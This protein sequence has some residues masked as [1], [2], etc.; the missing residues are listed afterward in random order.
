M[1]YGD[2]SYEVTIEEGYTTGSARLSTG[3]VGTY[4]YELSTGDVVVITPAESATVTHVAEGT[5]KNAYSYTLENSGYYSN[6]TKTEGDL[7]I[8]PATLTVKTE[9]AEKPYDGTALTA[10]GNVTGYKNNETQPG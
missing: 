4:S 1:T 10:V 3:D 2:E 8:T 9:S 7:S 6:V 5:V